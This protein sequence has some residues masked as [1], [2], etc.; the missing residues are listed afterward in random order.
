MLLHAFFGVLCVSAVVLA[1][2]TRSWR[3]KTL[4]AAYLVVWVVSTV[5]DTVGVRVPWLDYFYSLVLAGL[6]VGI[7]SRGQI[8][9]ELGAPLEMWIIIPFFCEAAIVM[10]NVL[11]VF[12]S[13]VLSFLIMQLLFLIQLGTICF[14]A[15]SGPAFR[16]KSTSRSQIR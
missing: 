9:R 2:T 12:F 16:A 11:G 14:V 4:S 8:E 1:F 10:T 13:P 7:Q 6:I 3:L 5:V 15:L